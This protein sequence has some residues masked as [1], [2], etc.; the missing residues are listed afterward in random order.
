MQKQLQVFENKEFG[1]VR[2]LEIDGVTWF[3]GKDVAGALGYSNPGKAVVEHIDGGDKIK[4]MIPHSQ[5]GNM[6]SQTMLVNESGLYSLIL[7]SKLPAAKAFK[8]W[9][10]S[11]ILPS[12]RKHGAYITDSTLDKLLNNPASVAKLFNLLKAEREKKEALQDY[13]EAIAPK[14][15][16]CDVILKCDNNI[17]V[18][19]IAKDYGMT[20]AAFNKLLKGLGV[21]YSVGGTWVLYNKYSNNGYTVTRTY[22][23]SERTAAVHTYWTQK[24]R[25]FI[26]EILKCFGVLP[27]AEKGGLVCRT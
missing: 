13:V 27:E 26:Y 3:V 9:V 24:G 12:V 11:E 5:N 8:R 21:Q 2:V 10:T 20:A 7:S 14:A 23:V 25:H 4:R 16:Y 17:P 6:V 15:F 22:H 18:S 19:V 1:K